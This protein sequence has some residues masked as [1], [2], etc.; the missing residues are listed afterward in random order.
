MLLTKK[1]EIDEVLF[2][3]LKQAA[4]TGALQLPA[5]TDLP[6]FQLF[7]VYKHLTEQGDADCC[8]DAGHYYQT[9]NAMKMNMQALTISI[10]CLILPII[11]RIICILIY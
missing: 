4:Q 5:N 8:V 10:M 6:L 3:D 1:D 9:A 2:A 11:I 7:E